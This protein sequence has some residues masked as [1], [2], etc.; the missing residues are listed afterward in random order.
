MQ[1][2]SFK[3]IVLSDLHL[4]SSH[5]KANQL[6]DFIE[7]V[8]CEKLILN[9]DIIDGWKLQKSGGRKKWAK[10]HTQFFR[11]IINMMEKDG[12]EIIYVRGNHDE[13]LDSVAPF[14]FANLKIVNY[15]IYRTFG[16]SYYVTHG[17]IFDSIT[18]G[19]GWLAKLGD[20][21]YDILLH[22]NKYVNKRRLKKGKS[23]FSLSKK[24]KS[25]VKQ[26]VSYIS[27]FEEEL[28]KLARKKRMYGVICGHIHHA[29]NEDIKGIHYLNSGDWVES[30]TALLEDHSGNWTIY[31]YDESKIK[32]LDNDE[33]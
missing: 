15:Y 31:Q 9:G 24:I 6:C 10:S 17:D 28:A 11:L 8:K 12:T 13:F 5:S 7:S 25:Q 29:A 26:A 1:R 3:T 20:V 33:K 30:M 27:D 32:H 22:L 16:K 19:A 4:G 18:T 21:G 14:S 2:N 23:Y